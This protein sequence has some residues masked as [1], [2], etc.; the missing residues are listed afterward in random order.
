MTILTVHSAH[1]VMLQ[2]RAVGMF[3]E[4][5]PF[6]PFSWSQFIV[7]IQPTLDYCPLLCLIWALVAKVFLWAIPGTARKHCR[8]SRSHSV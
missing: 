1:A 7:G 6:V 3:L 5:F 4:V 2:N 8:A